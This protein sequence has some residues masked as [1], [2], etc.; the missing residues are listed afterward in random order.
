M[1]WDCTFHLVDTDAIEQAIE[2]LVIAGD[3]PPALLSAYPEQ[4]AALWREAARRVLDEPPEQ[5]CQIACQIAIY[6]ASSSLPHHSERGVALSFGFDPSPPRRSGCWIPDSCMSSPQSMFAAL[7]GKRPEL[8]GKF[9]TCFETNCDTGVFIRPEHIATALQAV[10]GHMRDIDGHERRRFVGL[11]RVL[12]A[13]RRHGLAYWEAT[14]L[15]VAQTRPELLVPPPKPKRAAPAPAVVDK[16]G[17]DELLEAHADGVELLGAV[18]ELITSTG[19]SDARTWLESKGPAH[20]CT[21]AGVELL[22]RE[23]DS[24]HV[25]RRQ[26]AAAM[27]AKTYKRAKAPIKATLLPLVMACLRSDD[28]VVL[29]HALAVE[30]APKVLDAALF[31]IVATRLELLRED[32]PAMLAA[33]AWLEVAILR[34]WKRTEAAPD[35]AGLLAAMLAHSSADVR[36]AVRRTLDRVFTSSSLPLHKAAIDIFVAHEQHEPVPEHVPLCLAVYPEL[37]EQL[38]VRVRALIPDVPA[39]ILAGGFFWRLFQQRADFPELTEACVG[40]LAHDNH[41]LRTW[42]IDRANMLSGRE[43]EAARDHLAMIA[44]ALERVESLD[45]A[46]ALVTC[47]DAQLV[48][49]ARDGDEAGAVALGVSQGDGG[50]PVDA[51]VAKLA[52]SWRA[53]GRGDDASA[54]EE[55]SRGCFDRAGELA[56]GWGRAALWLHGDARRDPEMLAQ[57]LVLHWNQDADRCRDHALWLA[58]AG[59]GATVPRALERHIAKRG[60]GSR[61]VNLILGLGAM[62]ENGGDPSAAI[63]VARVGFAHQQHPDFL[64]NESCALLALGDVEG[65]A[66]TLSRAIGLD[67]KQAQDARGDSAFAGVLD[68]PSF[69]PLLGLPL[70]SS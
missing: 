26:A 35:L 8:D 39:T 63:Q 38:R 67:P 57:A 33:A 12:W 66:Q 10:L 68:H 50:N 31:E 37:P 34:R 4:G 9:R 55:F 1:G 43:V 22:A 69:A 20:A 59:H 14:D 6:V 65:A 30:L 45:H 24:A 53:A 3:P 19:S 52:T 28:A 70:P 62:L 21:L 56:L 40:F 49:L 18:F 13:A 2:A 61:F 42:A 64:Y 16:S 32:P 5:A 36:A 44:A 48:G 11:E 60:T 17:L 47:V 7:L 58:E 54:L 46:Q 23:L 25:A 41:G 15:G 27:L 29:R 51:V